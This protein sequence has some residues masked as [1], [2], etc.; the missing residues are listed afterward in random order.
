M[1]SRY[2]LDT[3]RCFNLQSRWESL[4]QPFQVEQ[5]IAQ[6][7]L[8]DLFKTYSS[9]GR[10]YHTLEHI[11]QVLATLND[12]R[13]LS[14][15]YA[16]IEFATWFHDAVYNPKANDNEEKSAEYAARILKGLEIPSSIIE[17][18][19]S[20][21]IKTKYHQ[22]TEEIDSKIFLDADLSILGASA[23]EYKVYAQLIRKEYVWLS[24]AKYRT[25]RKQ[26]LQSFLNRERIYF[27]EKMF[28]ALEQQA[29]QNIKEEMELL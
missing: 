15:N 7:V 24:P 29:R 13:S 18:V 4:L 10:Y 12:L 28:L 22:N 21:I 25:G 11:E 1:R 5:K 16:A 14:Q 8:L 23:A 26:V 2:N 17:A 3:E 27:T 6:K 19:Y 20:L 9:D